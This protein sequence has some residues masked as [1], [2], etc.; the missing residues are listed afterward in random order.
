[1]DNGIAPRHVTPTMTRLSGRA[2]AFTIVLT[3]AGWFACA[4]ALSVA[5]S[6]EFALA[7]LVTAPTIV[8]GAAVG[9]LAGSSIFPAKR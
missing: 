5:R 7:L 9:V 1:M 2:V 3:F 6:H 8:F 4:L